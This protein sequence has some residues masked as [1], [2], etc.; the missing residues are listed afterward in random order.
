M[1]ELAACLKHLEDKLQEANSALAELMKNKARLEQ[2]IKI[3]A[4]S[5]LIDRQKCMAIRRHFPYNVV[6]TRFY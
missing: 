1:S 4:N 2:N 3:K 6:S 5:L